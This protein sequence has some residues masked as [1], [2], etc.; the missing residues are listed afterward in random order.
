MESCGSLYVVSLPI[1]NMEDISIRALRILGQVDL[2]ATKDTRRTQRFLRHYRIRATLTTYDRG[3]APEKTPILLDRL[4]QG[5]S[6]ALVSDGGTPC[7]YDPG[8]RLITA[9]LRAGVP[10]V[11]VPGASALVTAVA[12]SGISGNALQFHG[13]LPARRQ[14]SIRLL[15]MLKDSHCTSVFFVSPLRLRVSL[16]HIQAVLGNRQV[17]V[18]VDLTKATQQILG[19]TIAQVLRRHPLRFPDGDVTLVVSGPAKKKSATSC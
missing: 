18:A 6:L 19:G 16:S 3:C 12:M 5:D 4:R 14:P 8:S 15:R 2:V 9:A 11:A 1:G 13:R 17:V 10:L 7:I